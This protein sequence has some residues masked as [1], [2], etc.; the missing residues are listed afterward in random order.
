MV[1]DRK[2]LKFSRSRLRRSRC[3]HNHF[4]GEAREKRRFASRCGWRTFSF[5]LLCQWWSLTWPHPG[6]IKWLF[7]QRTLTFFSLAPSALAMPSQSFCWGGA[8]KTTVREP[9]CLAHFQFLPAFVNGGHLQGQIR[10]ELDSFLIEKPSN[11]SRSRLRRSRCLHSH[12]VGEAREKLSFASQCVW[13]I[14]S[15]RML[16]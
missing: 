16:L 14:F 5:P 15:F 6:Y 3:L 9:V 10:G 4:V 11:F 13:R 1:F 8:R 12:F 7:D 2:T